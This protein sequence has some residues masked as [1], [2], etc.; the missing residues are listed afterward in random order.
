MGIKL[1]DLDYLLNDYKRE[2]YYKGQWLG[3]SDDIKIDHWV[4]NCIVSSIEIED[5]IIEINTR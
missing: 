3:D 4:F 5:S 2:Y 1:R